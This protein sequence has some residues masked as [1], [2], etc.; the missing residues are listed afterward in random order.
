[1]KSPGDLDY[2]LFLKEDLFGGTT[3]E[4]GV[5]TWRTFFR[6]GRLH[7]LKGILA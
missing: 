5:V 2:R 3:F 4:S 6:H 1:M 7:G